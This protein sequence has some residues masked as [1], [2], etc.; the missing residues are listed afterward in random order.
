MIGGDAFIMFMAIMELMDYGY[1]G[2]M[3]FLIGFV[4]VDAVLTFDYI[5]KL[6]Q[7]DKAIRD[8]HYEELRLRTEK[9]VRREMEE[10]RQKDLDAEMAAELRRTTTTT[11]K[12]RTTARKKEE[13]A[14]QIQDESS[15]ELSPEELH[16]MLSNDITASV[17][18]KQQ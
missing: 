1:D 7:Q 14:E 16:E 9:Q 12:K 10:E 11:R 13:P 18:G 8:Q 2:L 17:S 6:N 5:R 3:V 15:D 4:A